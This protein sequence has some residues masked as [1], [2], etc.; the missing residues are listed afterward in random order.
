MS[1]HVRELGPQEVYEF[2]TP[3]LA[4][5]VN[6]EG[7]YRVDANPDTQTTAVTIRIGSGEG[8]TGGQ[9]F[10]IASR[11]QAVV[12]GD[13]QANYRLQSVPMLDEF[14]QWCAAR[15]RRQIGRAVQQ[16]CRDRSRM[17]SSA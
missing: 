12:V 17:P 8:N 1:V 6:S 16:E 14:D 15:D 2:D 9:V 5:N 10:G 7:E 3:N 11:Q 4:F 13:E